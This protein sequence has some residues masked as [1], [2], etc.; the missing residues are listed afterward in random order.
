MNELENTARILKNERPL[1]TSFW[2]RFGWHTWE[3]W[4]KPYQPN[5]GSDKHIQTKT[6]ACCNKVT[7]K[8]VYPFLEHM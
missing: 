3:K 4:C 8:K 7:I 5:K 1:V 6:C 2:C